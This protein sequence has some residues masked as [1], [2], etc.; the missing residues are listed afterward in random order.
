MKKNHFL[1][2][3]IIQLELSESAADNL[4]RLED[5]LDRLMLSYHKPELVVGVETIMPGYKDTIPG[6]L[7][8]Y[9]GSLAKKYGIYFIP[10]TL[11]ERDESL[12]KGKQYNTAVVFNPKGEL[13]GKYRKTAPWYPAEDVTMPRNKDDGYLV[14]DIPE[15][16][17]KVG[18]QICYDINFPEVSRNLTLMG[19][20]VLVKLTMD[21]EELYKINDHF[22][23]SRAV[24][25][26]AYLICTNATGQ[27][28]ENSLY[29]HSMIV[30]PEGDKLWEAS[31]TP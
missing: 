13:I 16:D 28:M 27:F 26:Q 9:L 14:F 7:T 6:I 4:Y 2:V 15:K 31:Q 19:A 8:D 18:V 29:G 3:G 12:P 30:S 17:T 10:G 25:N 22:H 11:S 1:N 5:A 23:I 21:P 24:E 20:E